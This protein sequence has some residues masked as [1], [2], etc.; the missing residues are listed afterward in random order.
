MRDRARA[1]RKRSTDPESRLWRELRG[2][3]FGGF[4]FRRQQPLG[5]CVVDFCYLERRLTIELDGGQHA[6]LEKIQRDAR[7]TKTLG[8]MGFRELRFW[9]TDIVENLD[10][11]LAE[12]ERALRA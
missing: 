3:R 1:L 12:I 10:G 4:K 8:R 11:V 7:R 2:R 5:D 6:E 9:N